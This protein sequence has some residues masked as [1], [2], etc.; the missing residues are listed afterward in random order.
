MPVLKW[1]L[2]TFGFYSSEVVVGEGSQDAH[3]QQPDFINSAS[4]DK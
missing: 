3:L 4:R 2:N 1:A